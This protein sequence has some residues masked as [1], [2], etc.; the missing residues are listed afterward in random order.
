MVR[1]RFATVVP[2]VARVAKTRFRARF[3][4]SPRSSI[5]TT[6]VRVG[7]DGRQPAPAVREHPSH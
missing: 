3:V 2:R 6:V 7:D 1:A 5:V 4:G